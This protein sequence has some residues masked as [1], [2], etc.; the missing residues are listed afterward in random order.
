MTTNAW[1]GLAL[2]A[3]QRLSPYVPGKPIDELERELGI[4]GAIKLASNENPL[5]PSPHA[6]EAIRTHVGR[7]HRYPDGNGYALKCSL[8][9]QLGV[10]VENI[11]LGNGSNDV[12]DLIARAFLGEGR[13]A[14]FS[15]YAFAVYPIS[16]QAVG[17]IA[18]LA[19]AL[20]ADH[21]HQPL[22]HDLEAMRR[23]V[24]DRT[25]V[26][27]LANPNNPTGTWVEKGALWDF[28]ASLPA[29]VL[30]VVD[31]AYIEYVEPDMDFPN[32]I[33]WLEDFPNLIVTRTFSKIHGLAGLRVGYAVSSPQ[34]AELLNR[35]RQPFNVNLLAQEAARAALADPEHV[36]RTRELNRAGLTQVREGLGKLGLVA[37]PSLGNFLCIDMHRPAM[38]VYDG[39]LRQGVI[40]RPVGNYGLPNFLR[41]SI[42]TEAENARFL[43]AL[44]K[45]LEEMR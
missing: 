17:G 24:D 1:L 40:V 10:D 18:Q 9:E 14:V 37:L 31:E 35:V 23:A 30:V 21:A 44:G 42:G 6:L 11:T 39:L 7:I 26:V 34:L 20:P 8:A 33:E 13:G 16:T 2:P 38:P 27:F 43:A 28:I 4:Q 22:G 5:G 15:E 29:R 45:V 12:L 32:A 36:R 41:V 19:K 25:R 3:V